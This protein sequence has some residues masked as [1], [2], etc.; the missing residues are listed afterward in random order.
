[1]LRLSR[2]L[3]KRN[4]RA[5]AKVMFVCQI[6]HGGGGGYR[7]SRESMDSCRNI[8]IAQVTLPLASTSTWLRKYNTRL[9]YFRNL[10]DFGGWRSVIEWTPVSSARVIAR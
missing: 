2:E 3:E 1:M 5:P 6:V 7:R 10:D 4:P 8:R 9:L